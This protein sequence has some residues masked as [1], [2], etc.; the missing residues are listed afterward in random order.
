MLPDT[1]HFLPKLAAAGLAAAALVD[2]R[3]RV[4]A[5]LGQRL[6]ADALAAGGGGG[7]IHAPQGNGRETV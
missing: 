1:K 5:D 6:R 7:G 4:P 2:L 3:E